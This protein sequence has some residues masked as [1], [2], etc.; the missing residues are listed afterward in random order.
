MITYEIGDTIRIENEGYYSGNGIVKD[1]K[2]WNNGRLMI[3]VYFQSKG[4]VWY[5]LNLL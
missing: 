1:I 2:E 5:D 4:T 3:A